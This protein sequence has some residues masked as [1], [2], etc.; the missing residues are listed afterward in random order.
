MLKLFA[1]LSTF[2]EVGS[3]ICKDRWQE[4]YTYSYAS[5]IT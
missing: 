5:A 4:G 2:K 1:T 3:I